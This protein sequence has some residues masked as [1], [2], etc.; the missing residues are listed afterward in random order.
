[1][2]NQEITKILESIG[3]KKNEIIIYI[4]LVKKGKSSINDLF[5]KTSIHRSN[6]YDILESLLKKGI[7][8]KTIINGKKYYFPIEPEDIL[9]YLKQKE[10]EFEKIIPELKK[11]ENE[12]EDERKVSLSEGVNSCKN[13]ISRILELKEIIFKYGSSEEIKKNLGTFIEE[14]HRR[15]IKAKIPIKIIYG[16]KNLQ[17]IK[18]LNQ[19]DFTKARYLPLKEDKTSTFMCKDKIIFIIW[20]NPLTIFVIKSKELTNSY[21][22]YFELL[23]AESEVTN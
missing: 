18:K 3:F 22:E 6:I 9:D 2:E 21:K 13:I 19:L 20:K 16:I 4:T 17:T 1:M 5:K 14:F 12:S 8:D 11:I 10:K 23:W 7:I 15:R